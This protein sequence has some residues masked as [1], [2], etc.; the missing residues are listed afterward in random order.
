MAASSKKSVAR[1]LRDMGIRDI[2]KMRATLRTRYKLLY[3]SLVFT[4]LSLCWYGVW[5][6]VQAVPI[7]NN[8]FVAVLAGLL[9][10][11]LTG[12]VNKLG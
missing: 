1:K 11:Y 8:P 6:G 10:L 2:F 4:G 7:L 12:R 9:L 5:K 3:V